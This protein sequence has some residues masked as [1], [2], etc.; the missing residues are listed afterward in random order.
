MQMN[1][2]KY[3]LLGM[4]VIIALAIAMM[5][6]GYYLNVSSEHQIAVRMDNRELEVYGAAV[7][8]RDILPA[9]RLERVNLTAENMT[10]AVALVDGRITE[11]YQQKSSRVNAGEAILALTNDTL[12]MKI[13]QAQGDIVKAEA[14]LNQAASN[15]HRYSRLIARNATSQEKVEE[16]ETQYR[17]AEAGLTQA[18]A[19]KEQLLVMQGQQWVTAPLSGEI[20]LLYQRPGAY[21]QAGTPVALI[22]DFAVL[23]CTL[24]STD[25]DEEDRFLHRFVNAELSFV[26]SPEEM[27]K[28]YGSQY[29]TGNAGPNQN[30]HARIIR[31]S[32]GL[33]EPANMRQVLV[34]IDN[35]ARLLEPHIYRNALLRVNTPV[36][37]LAVPLEAMLNHDNNTVLVVNAEG[38]VE[39][40]RI[41]AGVDDG[42]YIEILEGLS[43]GDVVITSDKEGLD[44]GSRVHVI[45]GEG[46]EE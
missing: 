33:E 36:R 27:H 10:D 12:P 32:P 38:R 42:K 41:K 4:S 11:V 35:A 13:S 24:T 18:Q 34:E 9:A 21:V 31:V 43:A 5:C 20:M 40:R 26:V 15:Y 39:S 8:E 7:R 44:E 14:A 37:C 45:I 30:F 29:G 28:L 3:F 19:Q 2:K 22:G 6:Y 46:G 17:A 16:A 25:A 1:L 23:Q